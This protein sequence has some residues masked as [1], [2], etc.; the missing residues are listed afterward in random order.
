MVRGESGETDDVDIFL[1]ATA[2]IP[3]ANGTVDM[4]N[5]SPLRFKSLLPSPRPRPKPAPVAAADDDNIDGSGPFRKSTVTWL[6]R[7]PLPPTPSLLKCP[8]VSKSRFLSRRRCRYHKPRST[9]R[10]RASPPMTPPAI[11][12]ALLE[13]PLL[14]SLS[15]PFPSPPRVGV[16]T[17]VGIPLLLLPTVGDVVVKGDDNGCTNDDDDGDGDGDGDDDDNDDD[18]SD[19]DG[20]G[21]LSVVVMLPLVDGVAPPVS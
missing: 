14:L 4:G 8:S 7:S 5:P 17:G 20:A 16:I 10:T 15:S 2:A 11:F 21:V 19:G 18:C 13:E 1:P 9:R 3:A 12:G 6:S